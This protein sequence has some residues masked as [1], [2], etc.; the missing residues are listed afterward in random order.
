MDGRSPPTWYAWAHLAGYQAVWFIAVL[1]G[2]AGLTW[3]GVLAGSLLIAVHL[4][5]H[6]GRGPLALRLLLA[7][8]IGVAIDALLIVSGTVTFTGAHALPPGWMII[9][10]PCFA[11][12]FDGLL[13]WVPTRPLLAVALGALGGPLAYAGGQALGALAFPGGTATALI[14]IALAWAL[15]TALLVLVWR[16]GPSLPRAQVAS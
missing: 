1:G 15:A 14:A 9:L 5:L 16:I 8:V 3:P 13:A 10:W 6:G 7:T 2:A 11:S 4:L 12:L